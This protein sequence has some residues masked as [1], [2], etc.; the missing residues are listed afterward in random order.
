MDSTA[1][2]HRQSDQ[3]STRLRFPEVRSLNADN[4]IIHT[5]LDTKLPRQW[6]WSVR[7]VDVSSLPWLGW[8]FVYAFLQFYFSISRC[9]ALKALVTMYGSSTDY[10]AIVKMS[11]LSLGFFEDFVCTTY[12][13]SAL[14]IFDTFKQMA[15]ERIG[16]SSGMTLEIVGGI[17]TFTVS[18]LLFLTMMAPFVADMMLVVYRDMRFSFGLLAT[19]IRERHHLK[20]APISSD[21]VQAAYVTAG[22]LVIIAALFALVRTWASWADLALWNPTQIV[23]NPVN[24][25]TN[26]KSS[27]KGT[28]GV[29]YEALALEDGT[30]SKTSVK[31]SET[32]TTRYQA[33]RAAVVVLGLVVVPAVA[34]AVRCACSPLVAYAALN[35]TLNELLL[36]M[37][38]PAPIDVELTNLI[39]NKP[40]VE[41]FIDKAEEHQRFGDD[42][43]YRRTTGF[44]GDLAFNVSIDSDNP[45][46]ILIIG[47]ES[48]RYRDSRYLVGEEDPSDLFKGTNLTITPNFDRWAKRGV[49]MRN[50]WSSIP[51]SRSLESVL[52]AQVPYHSNTQSGITGGRKETKLSGLP[53][54]FSQKGYETFFTTGSSIELDAW[55]VFLPS[56]GY[57]YVW[58]NNK[59]K[60]M[61]EKNLNISRQDWDGDAHRGFGW[62]VHDDL[63][64]QLLGDFLLKKRTTQIEKTAQGEPKMP[65]FITH[66][67]ISSHEP[68]QSWPKWYEES[69]KPDFSAMYEGELHA[70]RIE[71]YMK[72]RYFTDMELGKF[73]DR[74][75]REGFLNDTIVVILGD[76]GQ[77]PEIDNANLHEESVTRVPAA[78]IAE[79]RLGDAVGLVIDDAAQQYDILNTLAD[80]TGL[81]KA[82]FQQNGVGRSLKRKIP[83]GERVVFTNDP[84]RKMAIVRG[85]ERLRYDAVTESM[86]LHDTEMDFHMTTDLLPFLKPDERAEWE[87]LREDGRRIAA[88]YKKRWDENCLLAVKCNN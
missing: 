12:F 45:P 31:Q 39:G 14:W 16:P 85:H 9:L 65:M 26:G 88:Y 49:A 59:M 34:V 76:H 70:D 28:G 52:F 18:W 42:T 29:K 55:N 63:S 25:T 74:M 53:Q 32:S 6:G 58:N 81:P 23:P 22:Y 84:M 83:F 13:A 3:H 71:R 38:E 44:S 47:V 60:R 4:L 51:T 7:G 68:Y 57:D 48:F 75:E 80:I 64:F 54:L 50:I 8:L 5:E 30:S 37:F 33:L 66:Y 36:H 72:V 19:L 86:M 61:A 46:N 15:L 67:T 62:G 21:E 77:A 43:L 79:G 87:A 27:K 40:W 56:H 82:G 69:E 1:P 11:A 41:K 10:T 35:V 78:I 73:M 2:L 20:D 17:A 24:N